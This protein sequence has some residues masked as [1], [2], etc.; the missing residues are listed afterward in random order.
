MTKT[1]APDWSRR[2]EAAEHNPYYARYLALVPDGDLLKTLAREGA[3]TL[4]LLR[5]VRPER[6][7]HRYAP[8]K[9]SVRE[10]VGHAI[11]AERVFGYR[12][13]AFA[14]G[15]ANPLPGFEEQEWAQVSNA[16]ERPL[17]ELCDEWERVRSS[18]VGLLRGLDSE[19]LD[20]TGT[21]S[22]WTVSVRALGWLIAGHAA[23]H[24]AV[25]EERYL[26]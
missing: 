1:G 22:G 21:A 16:H 9:W 24:R 19:A 4:A 8:G 3:S 11:D 7:V 14:R 5:G 13:L 18:T 20:R 26:R 23:H 15:D 17:A 10:V 25:L 6:E 12:A 2:P